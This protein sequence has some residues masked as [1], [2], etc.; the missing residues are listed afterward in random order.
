MAMNKI[1]LISSLFAIISLAEAAI[2]DSF[3]IIHTGTT[4]LVSIHSIVTWYEDM[5]NYWWIGGNHSIDEIGI[6]KFWIYDDST[7][8]R[9]IASNRI[10]DSWT[11]GQNSDLYLSTYLLNGN[12]V[13]INTNTMNIS[14]VANGLTNSLLTESYGEPNVYSLKIFQNNFLGHLSSSTNNVD[15]QGQ[16]PAYLT[17]TLDNMELQAGE[18]GLNTYNI[19]QTIR[20]YDSI[21]PEP[22]TIAFLGLSSMGLYGYRRREKILSNFGAIDILNYKPESKRSLR[23]R[24]KS[25]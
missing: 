2:I 17:G 23:W 18:N 14:I 7:S 9:E 1:T 6:E 20:I 25:R 4:E 22:S 15:L 5:G 19:T 13:N 24:Y 8:D 16:S 3:Q 21:I 12:D 10:F 11:N